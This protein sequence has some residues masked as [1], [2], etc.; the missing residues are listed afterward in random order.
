[1]PRLAA[2]PKPH[3]LKFA[4]QKQHCHD[5][6]PPANSVGDTAGCGYEKRAEHA[7]IISILLVFDGR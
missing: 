3:R 7:S 5:N 1:M 2:D 6:P 4:V